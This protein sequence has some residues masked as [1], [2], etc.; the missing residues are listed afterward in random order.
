[1]RRTRGD[2]PTSLNSDQLRRPVAPGGT[3]ADCQ[4][5]RGQSGCDV[6]MRTIEVAKLVQHFAN[7]P[8]KVSRWL[9]RDSSTCSA[10]FNA[11]R[12]RA[13]G[14]LARSCGVGAP[15][16]PAVPDRWKDSASTRSD[17]GF[18]R[19][20]GS[21]DCA[22]ASIDRPFCERLAIGF[23]PKPWACSVEEVDWAAFGHE[24]TKLGYLIGQFGWFHHG[25]RAVDDCRELLEVLASCPDD[26][27]APALSHLLARSASTRVRTWAEGAPTTSSISRN[28]GGIAGLGVVTVDRARGGLRST[29][30]C[31]R[32]RSPISIRR[33]TC[34][35][36]GHGRSASPRA[37]ATRRAE[38]P[39][40][41]TAEG[42]LINADP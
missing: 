8:R 27:E 18:H 19:R 2:R 5:E 36:C 20:R 4:F 26:R 17:G 28:G 9:I 16:Q 31:S 25:H 13:T 21:G 30:P 33:S 15:E 37:S 6:W 12:R 14:R 11:P 41:M 29:R 40:R 22:Y 38:R 32:R 3:A 24:G 7:E 1:M 39:S 42:G 10:G 34:R 35:G 23:D